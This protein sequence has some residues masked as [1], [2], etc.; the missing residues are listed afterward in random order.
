M[1][2]SVPLLASSVGMKLMT[3]GRQL[4]DSC[5]PAATVGA[6]TFASVCVLTIL[7]QLKNIYA[8]TLCETERRM[9]YPVCLL[10]AVKR[11]YSAY[12]FFNK[13]TTS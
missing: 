9:D 5:A 10:H 3:G 12:C 13:V 7:F 2:E 1:L 11:W 8:L 4:W 6:N